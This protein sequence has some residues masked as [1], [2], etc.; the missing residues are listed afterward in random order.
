MKRR[1]LLGLI[2]GAFAPVPL[3]SGKPEEAKTPKL[4]VLGYEHKG[5][6][7]THWLIFKDCEGNEILRMNQDVDGTPLSV[8]KV[9]HLRN[10]KMA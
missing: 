7:R 8:D 3:V 6:Y 5:T 9:L 1:S 2:A 10:I 4:E